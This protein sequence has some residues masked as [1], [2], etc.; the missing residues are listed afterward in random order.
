MA[1]RKRGA[2]VV[3]GATGL[4]LILLDLVG[5]SVPD[6]VRS[7]GAT[8]MSP[9]Q[10]VSG[11]IAAPA[12]GWI[13]ATGNFASGELRAA[14]WQE[15]APVITQVRGDQRTAELDQLLG[16]L[17][18]A[19]LTVVP[20]RVVA[21]PIISL[22]V[23]N[24]LI[25]T[26]SEDEVSVDRAVISGQG[27][28]GRTTAVTPGTAE[29]KLLSAP[30]SSVGARILRTGQACVVVGTGDPNSLSVRVLD[31]LADVQIG[32]SV[33][34]FGSKDGRPFPPD[35]PVGT[36]TAID[37]DGAGGRLIRLQPAT[38]LTGLDLVGVIMSQGDRAVR[39]PIVGVPP[40]PEV[41]QEPEVYDEPVPID[42]YAQDQFGF[43]GAGAGQNGG[44]Q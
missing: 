15:Q 3:L 29:V 6:T 5:G 24:V 21:Y 33:I 14:D 8:A 4:T 40:E 32:D 10:T 1:S 31:P 18:T 27:L 19:D 39:A 38:N 37:D 36:I 20:A 41:P 9:L 13:E 12:V 42:P 2:V 11:A 44:F 17:N 35:F 43:T 28:V 22:D 30:D 25:D 26:G 34:T 16:L 23:T 7:I